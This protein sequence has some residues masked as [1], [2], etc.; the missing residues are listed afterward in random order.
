MVVRQYEGYVQVDTFHVNG[1]LTLGENIADYGGV[2]TGYDALQRALQRNGRRGKVEGFTPEQRFFIA[3]AQSYRQ[4][5]RPVYLR[6]RV[7]VDPHSPEQWRVNGPL[8]NMA[9]FAAAFGCKPDDPMVRPTE[10][11]PRIW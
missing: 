5:N 8:S 2:L 4:H 11:V 3:Y 7:T 10:L 6:T 1:R 9:E